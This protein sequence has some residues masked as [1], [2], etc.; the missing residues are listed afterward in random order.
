MSTKHKKKPPIKLAVR[1]VNNPEKIFYQFYFNIARIEKLFLNSW[2]GKVEWAH[3]YET[4]SGTLLK[5]FD[6]DTHQFTTV[7]QNQTA[8]E[9]P[10]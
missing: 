2:Y 7:Q 1:F 8:Q 3:I 4:D 9:R 10:V 5:R 6:N